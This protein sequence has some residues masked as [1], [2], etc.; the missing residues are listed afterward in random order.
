[1][2]I[3]FFY[4]LE[5]G[6]GFELGFVPTLQ[7]CGKTISKTGQ[8]RYIF[9]IHSMCFNPEPFIVGQPRSLWGEVPPVTAFRVLTHPVVVPTIVSSPTTIT[10]TTMRT[11]TVPVTR[12]YHDDVPPDIGTISTGPS[13]TTPLSFQMVMVR[14]CRIIL[15]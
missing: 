9:K 11:T 1:M 10:T 14:G 12:R 7:S 3:H 5:G 13:F 15:V 6:G 2:T 4:F 8:Q